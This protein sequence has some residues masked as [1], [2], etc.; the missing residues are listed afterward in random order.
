[1]QQ[2]PQI[3][4]SLQDNAATLATVAAIRTGLRIARRTRQVRRA[5]A[6]IARTAENL[7]IIDKLFFAHFLLFLEAQKYE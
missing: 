7:H 6:T 4:I 2:R 1:M 5:R 3:A